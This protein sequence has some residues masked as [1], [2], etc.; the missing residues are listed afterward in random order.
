MQIGNF[1]IGSGDTAKKPS[2]TGGEAHLLWENLVIRYDLIEALHLY[3]KFA[4]DQDL[5]KF[6]A[7]YLLILEKQSTGLEKELD[8]H[9]MPLPERPPKTVN[10]E[11]SNPQVRDKFLFRRLFTIQQDFL[12]VCVRT[13]RVMVINDELRRL[14]G[15]Y[16]KDKLKVYDLMC[17][18]GKKKGWLEVPPFMQNE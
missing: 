2:I 18:F 17:E 14:I 1:H 7:D 3:H 12:D 10:F 9:K 11:G 15:T 6:F 8:A 4:H 13:I 16:F 5:K